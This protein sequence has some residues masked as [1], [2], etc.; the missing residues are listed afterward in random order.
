MEDEIL[1]TA[2]AEAEGKP[3]RVRIPIRAPYNFVPFSDTVIHRY[4]WDSFPPGHHMLQENLLSGEIRVQITAQTPIFISNGDRR[5][6]D[7]VRDDWGVYMIPASSL[8][9]LLRHNM[10]ILGYGAI[11][12]GKDFH[13]VRLFHKNHTDTEQVWSAVRGGYLYHQ[14]DRYF[15]RPTRGEV[16]TL[17]R[18][19]PVGAEFAGEF[20]KTYPVYYKAEGKQVQCLSSQ[21]CEDGRKGRLLCPTE[22]K[23]RH[24][25]CGNLYI[26]PEEDRCAPEVEMTKESVFAYKDDFAVRKKYMRPQEVEFKTLPGGFVRDGE[27]IPVFYQ[28]REDFT[29][30][31][32]AKMLRL[33]YEHPV[34]R[35]IPIGHREEG[36]DY[37]E[38]IMGY[39]RRKKGPRSQFTDGYRSRVSVFDFPVQGNP[40]PMEVCRFSMQDPKPRFHDAY[41]QEGLSYNSENFRLSGHKQYWLKPPMEPES[42]EDSRKYTPMRPLP[43]GT[44]F[45][46]KIRYRNLHPDELGL[47][48]WCLRLE[49]GCMQ[50]VGMGKPYGYGR[51][52]IDITRLQEESYQDFYSSFDAAPNTAAASEE[53]IEELIRHYDA[54]A[55]RLAGFEQPILEQ[56]RIQD[57]LYMK[58]T[59]REDVENVSY[60]RQYEYNRTIKGLQTVRSIREAAENQEEVTEPEANTITTGTDEEAGFVDLPT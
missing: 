15:I 38:A 37:T 52:K 56:P 49:E 58:R 12:S 45:A 60:M 20:S 2:E 39:Y 44:V 4:S 55:Q 21:M 43:A 50:S 14:A 6:P 32:K 31:G 51:V 24:D 40:K 36:M 25:I 53:R 9:G 11:R 19:D 54:Y 5:T 34:G 13:N 46:G 57:F 1:L 22:I 10:Q 8:R 29:I 23:G 41:V 3:E 26:F 18:L 17:S 33:A 47:L 42:D 16:L 7:F 30:I 59:I 48:L 27:G 35:G 28:Q